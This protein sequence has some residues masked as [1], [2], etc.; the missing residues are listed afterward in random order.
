MAEKKYKAMPPEEAERIRKALTS[1]S[2]RITQFDKTHGETYGG[3]KPFKK[4]VQKARAKGPR[5]RGRAPSYG[6]GEGHGLRGAPMN[7]NQ[8]K[9]LE[10]LEPKN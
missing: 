10:Q 8:G 9:L 1:I 7:K 3:A 4:K 6:K 5:P 2:E